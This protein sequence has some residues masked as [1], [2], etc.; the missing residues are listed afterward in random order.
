MSRQIGLMNHSGRVAVVTDSG[1][2]IP[3]EEQERLGIHMVSARLNFGA[4]EYIDY[5]TLMP[6]DLYRMLRECDEAPKTSQPP[7]GD[8]AR[9]YDLLIGH[10][11]EVMSVGLSEKLSGTTQA[12]RTAAERFDGRV[13][14]FDS[15]SGSCGEGLMAIIAAEAA[16]QDMTLD[17]IEG[18]VLELRPDCRTFGFADDLAYLV[19]G[20]RVPGWIKKVTDFLHISPLLTEKNG[21]FTLAGNLVAFL[22]IRTTL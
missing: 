13:R 4:T 9:Q 10:G 14:V 6:S 20:G 19:R 8:F 17:E 18:L 21:R 11:Y 12:A 15:M 3:E 7:V 16:K 2:D 5:V 1:A 22:D